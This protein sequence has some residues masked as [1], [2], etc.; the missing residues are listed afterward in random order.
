M[1]PLEAEQIAR[2]VDRHG[3]ALRA[4]AAQWSD[5]PEDLVQE[6]FCRLVQQRQPPDQP[7]A[8]LFRVVRNLAHETHRAG[9]RRQRR[10][11]HAA[12]TERLD[13]DLEQASDAHDAATLL[14][15]LDTDRRE[16]VIM[17]LWGGL[18]LEETAAACGVSVATVH[19]RYQAALE[20][21]RQRMNIPCPAKTKPTSHLPT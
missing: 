1:L 2:L 12:A 4:L 20:E 7:G 6:A 11:E 13:V 10:E 5:S 21:L 17:R 9:R 16:V 3:A 18:T 14:G 15:E 8:W 19:R